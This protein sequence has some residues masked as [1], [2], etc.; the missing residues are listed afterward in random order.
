MYRAGGQSR[1]I[2]STVWENEYGCAEHTDLAESTFRGQFVYYDQIRFS[3]DFQEKFEQEVSQYSTMLAL[4]S[5]IY[6]NEY[7]R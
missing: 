1:V 7:R 3:L 4:A 5:I 6:L 2:V